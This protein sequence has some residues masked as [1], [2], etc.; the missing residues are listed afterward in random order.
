[1]LGVDDD[2]V[3]Y[4]DDVVMMMTMRKYNSKPK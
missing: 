2:G 1:M 3:W 4:G